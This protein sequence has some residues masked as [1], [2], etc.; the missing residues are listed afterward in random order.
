MISWIFNP[1]NM[2]NGIFKELFKN[3]QKEFHD[4]RIYYCENL[5]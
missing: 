4:F 5:N 3:H 1:Y 2:Q